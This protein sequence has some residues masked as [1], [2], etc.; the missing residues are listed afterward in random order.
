M[1]NN[2]RTENIIELYNIKKMYGDVTAVEDFNLKVKR[3]DFITFLGP[4]GCGKTTTLR[5]IAGFELPT[6]GHITL[7]G[8]DISK[9]PPYERP[10]N[11]VFQRYALFPHLNI[12][13]NIAFGLKLKTVDV[14]YQNDKG[15]T[16]TRKEKLSKKEIEEKVKRALEIVDLEGFEKRSIDTLSG[17]QQQR[18]AIARAIVNEPEILL[19]DEPLGALDLKMRKEMQIELKSMHEKLGI[20]FIYVTHDQEEALT[21]SD[22]IVVMSDG[23]IQQIGTPEEIYNEPENAFVADFIGESNI[24]NGKVAG[25]KK[26][27]F[28]NHIFD[29]V[30]DF[31]IGTRVDVVVRPEDVIMKPKGQGMLDVL[32]D[33]VVFKGIHYEITVLSG[34]I[35][36][37]IQSIKNAVVGDTIGIEIEPDGIHLIENNVTTNEFDGVITKNNTVEFGDGEYECDVTQL[38]HNSTLDED[39]YLIKSDGEKI[40]L[41]GVEVSVSVPLFNAIEMSD[42]PDK[43]GATGNIISL[44]YKGDHYQYIVRTENEF[45]YILDDED[46]WNENDFVSLIIPKDKIKLTLK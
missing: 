7:D 41:A 43:G 16:I 39:G 30:D 4:S 17:G 11:T 19:L 15:E 5:M 3:G 25:K 13:D 36:I 18:I 28:C 27:R 2:K 12:Y 31:P 1:K 34:D 35:E 10:I 6:E 23:M 9:L 32:V 42:D 38:Y 33:S 20:T 46:L 26:V 37:V 44:I 40:D 45:D 14:T 22:K 21:M 24:L 8:E 29:C